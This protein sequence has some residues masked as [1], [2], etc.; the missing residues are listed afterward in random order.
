[1]EKRKILFLIPTLGG[2]GAEKVLVNLVNNLDY[3]TYDVTLQTLFK[4]STNAKYL[5]KDIHFVE[6]HIKQFRGSTDLISLI[7]LCLLYRLFVG[8]KYD[9]V[10]SYLEGPTARIASACPYK[11]TKL[12]NWIH[13]EFTNQKIASDGFI[14]PKK[15]L[16]AYE[17]FDAIVC[18]AEKVKKEFLRYFPIKK[19][20]IVLY[21]TNEENKIIEKS[22]EPLTDEEWKD[23]LKVISVGRLVN[24]KGYDRLIN[25]HKRLITDG[26]YHHLYIIGTGG[27][28]SSLLNQVKKLDIHDT[29]HFLGF[30]DN[31]YKY[32]SKADLFVCSSNKEGFSTAVTEAFILGVPVVST[33]VSGAKEMLG[34]HNEYGI[35]TDISEDALYEGVKKMLSEKGLLAHYKKQAIIRGQKFMKAN[36][37]KAVMHLFDKLCSHK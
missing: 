28:L 9:I 6:G 2:G 1:M 22:N 14:S 17:R 24:Q 20:P 31:P 5:N 26:I 23:D 30:Q 36:T 27:N 18:V 4:P 29:V 35:V 12:I 33:D 13:C 32:V 8:K 25:V 16:K 15:A 19:A 3:T 7:P 37:V 11:G 21:N 10:I 34:E